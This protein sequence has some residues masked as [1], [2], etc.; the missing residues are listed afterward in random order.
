MAPP[1][2]SLLCLLLL[3]IASPALAYE[4][5]SL[6][7]VPGWSLS[8]ANGSVQ[9]ANVRVPGYA[10]ESLREA[11]LVQDPLYRYGEL[12]TRWVALDAWNWTLIWHSARHARLM[13]HAQ[14]ALRLGGVDTFA[15]VFLNGRHVAAVDNFHRFVMM[16]AVCW[17]V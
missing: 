1:S 6:S 7:E 4:V 12:E 8:N 9:L 14:V 10:L 16:A 2:F 5:I 11:G 17:G 15:D 3:A 13:A